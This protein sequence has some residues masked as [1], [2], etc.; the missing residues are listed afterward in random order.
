MDS[1][2][3]RNVGLIAV[4]AL[5]SLGLMGAAFARPEISAASPAPVAS[6]VVSGAGAPVVTAPST[7][8]PTVGT[9]PAGHLPAWISEIRASPARPAPA[10]TTYT[11]SAAASLILSAAASYQAVTWNVG[12]GYGLDLPT[13]A[14]LPVSVLDTSLGCVTTWIGTPPTTVTISATPSSAPIGTAAAYEFELTSPSRAATVLFGL[15][16]NGAADL[17]FTLT[18]VNSQLGFIS[19]TVNAT[20]GSPAAVL[21]GELAGGS[22]FL[23][24]HPSADIDWEP[25]PGY[26]TIGTTG[27]VVTVPPIW[28]V[29]FQS[30]CV[31]GS[32]SGGSLFEELDGLTG[33]VMGNFTTSCSPAYDVTFSES[34][35]PTGTPWAVNAGGTTNGS[36]GSSIGFTLGLGSFNYTISTAT[37]FAP[38]N[39]TGTVVVSGAA[40]Q[41]NVAFSAA[42]TYSASFRESGLPAGTLWGVSVNN[43][44]ATTNTTTLVY[45]ETNGTYPY[46]ITQIGNEVLSTYSG[47]FTLNGAGTLIRVTFSAP[48]G[49]TVSLTESGLPSGTTWG[50]LAYGPTYLTAFST[51]SGLNFSGPNG[52]YYVIPGA[53]SAYYAPSAATSFLLLTVNGA[54]TSAA[55]TFVYQSAYPISFNE[56]GLAPN[57]PWLVAVSYIDYNSTA[58][59]STVTFTLPNGTYPFTAGGASGY[60]ASPPNGT[61]TVNG[62]GGVYNITFG[63]LSTAASYPVTFVETGLAALTPW[64]VTLAGSTLAS[65]TPSIAFAEPNGSWSF[66]VGAVSGYTATPS[67]GLVFVNGHAVTESITFTSGSPP[68]TTTYALTFTESGLPAGKNWSVTVGGTAHYSTTGSIVVQEANGTYSFTVPAIGGLTPTPA[69]GSVTVQGG[70]VTRAIAFSSTGPTP[71]H[72]SITFTETGLP[73]GTRW[74]VTLNGSVVTSSS[75]TLSFS[76]VNGSY[77]Y[78]VAA[79]SGY[80]DSPSSGTVAL[81]GGP[82]SVAIAFQSTSGTP[83]GP[84]GTSTAT[85]LGLPALEGYA[86]VGIIVVLVIVGVLALLLR[87]RRPPAPSATAPPAHVG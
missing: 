35:L 29:I 7:A 68:G 78:T 56:T 58:T 47:T 16:T 32:S 39:T 51:S 36:T 66:S 48:S 27:S 13:S 44:T 11:Y 20:L 1:R 28:Y 79:V 24:A 45:P 76:E 46:L 4:I 38:A 33:A 77:S 54:N 84:G 3:F 62:A 30:P 31:P 63:P 40:V 71:A 65:S 73:S 69:S 21:A 86:L 67:G 83:P 6:V 43:I 55:V 37:G 5:L 57:T 59:N 70:A 34:G 50:A 19:G 60:A 42:T 41:V 49:Y 75:A 81:T 12:V 18:C 61:F 2:G 53:G 64:S 8:A 85:F 87:N 23:A 9:A 17:L 74:S 52:T 26:P 72:Y 15:V 82:Q 10:T 14:T 22:A 80:T 25:E